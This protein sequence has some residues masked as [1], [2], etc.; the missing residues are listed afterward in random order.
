[1][2]INLLTAGVITATAVIATYLLMQQSETGDATQLKPLYW[3]APMDA[4]FRRDGPGK[5]PMG[6]DLVPVYAGQEPSGD[7]QEVTLDAA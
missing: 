3:V 2:K 4:N 5:S 7:P 1:M 6:M